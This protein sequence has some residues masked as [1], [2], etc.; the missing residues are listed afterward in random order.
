MAAPGPFRGPAIVS[1]LPH[2]GRLRVVNDNRGLGTRETR[3]NDMLSLV[4]F[5]TDYVR[6]L[7]ELGQNDAAAKREQIRE[8]LG[9]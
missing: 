5:Q 1:E 8:F 4:M 6:H 7:I 9:L 2:G 3:S